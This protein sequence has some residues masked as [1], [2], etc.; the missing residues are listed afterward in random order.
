MGCGKQGL[1]VSGIEDVDLNLTFTRI[2]ATNNCPADKPG[3]NT[4]EAL[5]IHRG[6][7]VQQTVI[8]SN[9][10]PRCVLT[11]WIYICTRCCQDSRS[12]RCVCSSALTIGFWSLR[13]EGGGRDLITGADQ[14]AQNR[15]IAHD[16]GIAANVARTRHVLGQRVQIGEPPHLLCLALVL[17]MLKNG[18]DV[19]WLIAVDQHTDRGVDKTVLMAVKVCIHQDVTHPVPGFVVKKQA[20][21][22]AGLPFNR[23]RGHPELGNLA[24]G[25]KSFGSERYCRHVVSYELFILRRSTH[26]V[27]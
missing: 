11:A 10:D 2:D 25:F 26:R 6:I 21:D 20:T 23:M 27:E 3:C 18:N 24:V 22:H 12:K 14:F 16:L 1:E 13:I 19:S 17:Q 15:A 7:C 4:T 9:I 5:R 8:T